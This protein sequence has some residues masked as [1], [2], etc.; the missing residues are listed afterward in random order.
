MI[1]DLQVSRLLLLAGA[2]P[3]AKT[4]VYDQSPL[5]CVAA[6]HGRTEFVALLLEFG[7]DVCCSDAKGLS[8]LMHAALGGNLDATQLLHQHGAKVGRMQILKN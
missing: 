3:D 2:D 5:L 1:Y 4:S 6:R 8:P 7:A